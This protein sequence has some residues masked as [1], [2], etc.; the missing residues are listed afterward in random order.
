MP[1]S[2]KKGMAGI[3]R[4]SLICL[5]FSMG[6]FALK[7]V[8][9]AVE[10]PE[11]VKEITVAVGQDYAPFY[12][13]NLEG[14]ADGWLVDVW[15]LWGQKT[16]IEVKFVLVPLAETLKLTKEGRVD[17]QGGCFYSKERA[18]YLD[19]VAP[20]G[21]SDTNF[22]FHK[23]IYGI[24]TLKDL[25]GFRIGVVKG[26]YAVGYLEKHLPNASLA[27]YA[28]NDALFDALQK[29]EIRVFVMDTPVALY[30]LNKRKQ[31]SNF[32]Y[33]SGRPLYSSDFMAA[34]KKGNKAMPPLIKEGLA[35][36]TPEEKA[37]IER[38]WVGAAQT[39]TEGVLTIACDRYYPPFTMLTPSGRAAGLLIDF[40]RLWS[41]KSV[42]KIE[43]I[44][45][46]WGKAIQLVKEGKADIHSG[47]FKTPE[48]EKFLSFSAPII[49]VQDNLAFRRGQNP[50]TL[51]ELAHETV[52]VIAGTGEESQL[53]KE[54]PEISLVAYEGSRELLMALQRREVLAVYDVGVVLQSAIQELGLQ[55]EIQVSLE[56]KPHR[57][58]FAGVLKKDSSTL[59]AI[60]RGI[61]QI[62]EE[63][64]RDIEARWITNKDLRQFSGKARALI[65]TAE[66]KD[67]LADHR[68][69]RLGI[70]PDFM[71]FEALGS[72]QVYEGISS[73][74]VDILNQKL[75]INMAP[76]KGL[77]LMEM[78]K[79]AIAGNLDVLP[80]ISMTPKRS[81]IFN[82]TRPY[83]NFPI[84]A[85]TREDA[86][87]LSG[88][89][90]LKG[91]R[92]A[93]VGGYYE[94]EMMEEHFPE[95]EL[96]LVE[97]IEQGLEAVDE[98]K[99]AAYVDRSASAIYAIRKL[100]LKDLKIAATTHYGPG[101]RFAVRKDW[102]QLASILENALQSIPEEE[103]EKIANHWINVR[104]TER[105]DWGFLIKT[106][107]AASVVI[108]LILA[109]ILFWNRR[110]SREVGE[111]KRAEER[112]QAIAATTPGAIIQARVD[113]EGRP[114]YLY[115]SAKAE[116]F[117]GMPS[118][119]VIQEKKGLNWHPDDQERI[120]GEVRRAASAEKD[121]NLVGRIQPL[122]SDLRWIRMNASPSRLPE[123]ALIYNGFMLDI[124]ERKLAEQEYLTSERK[125]KAMSQA[126][127]DALVMINGKGEV[128]FWNPA[129]ESLF[130]YTAEEAM[131][132]NF[133]EMAAPEADR[134][135][136]LAGLE[137]F[138]RTGQGEM[139][140]KTVEITAQDR[141]G[142]TFPV[143]VNISSFQVDNEW[144]AVGTVRDITERKEAEENLRLTQNTV[145]KAAL[146]IFWVDPETGYFVYANEAAC[147]SLGY[148]REELLAM[149][150]P[151]I[152][153]G[154]YEEKFS[155][156][157][158]FLESNPQVEAEG[159]HRTKDGRL[160]KVLLSIV[161]TQLRGRR[162]IAVFARDITEQKQAE[163]T[164][165]QKLEELEE[166]NNLVV[167]REE[168]MI[169]LKEEINGLL[170]QLGQAEKYD[171]VE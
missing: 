101:L 126:V 37:A 114:E 139:I 108:A 170:V 167:G 115:L 19:Y 73:S 85:V 125:I 21:K 65:L 76:V 50:L 91:E 15:R 160:L 47:L 106:G 49:A 52:G 29:G 102:P 130:G 155:N 81:E 39:K 1:C 103:R 119:R 137:R 9:A 28:T 157:L 118:Q 61:S 25:L 148:T 27:Q 57:N 14:K 110:L 147:N 107:I 59:E 132:R 78:M 171:I 90:D 8:A 66:E 164:L 42:R 44:F 33:Y 89:R 84:V 152:D 165:K 34:V 120:Y 150:V 69:I 13:Q 98:G 20:L 56:S 146:N 67:W 46:D 63:E 153:V 43:F 166:F 40:W 60:N 100:G 71:P 23:N 151:E 58:L 75:G 74:Y 149:I 11:T 93:V 79:A 169:G 99:A 116:A 86:P 2:E 12:F 105:T 24:E 112:F 136:A 3:F 45:D 77:S 48:R 154:F 17:A 82:F 4:L 96:L 143:E 140:G 127:D 18:T 95:I 62:T 35:M 133:H 138:S 109:I 26:D 51:D 55:G 159:V 80:C 31:L 156:L 163:E 68:E 117:F 122:G 41:E 94:Q 64:L 134:I 70:D 121:L 32:N 104:F 88:I 6:F 87:F 168:K 97:N 144:F 158:Q 22:F 16:G 129:A 38:H 83:L 54:H 162:V 10:P 30:L 113:A 123:G 53:R 7:P 5:M 128:M 141:T 161:L 92:V 145:D 72:G 142:R 111:R 36:I 131:G 135:G 124:T